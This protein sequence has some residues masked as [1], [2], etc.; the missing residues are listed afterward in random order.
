MKKT[1]AALLVLA[2]SCG[3]SPNDAPY[4]GTRTFGAETDQLFQ[5]H[6]AGDPSAVT[7]LYD[8]HG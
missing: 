1:G 8:V 4:C 6:P 7:T 5:V 2:V 3:G